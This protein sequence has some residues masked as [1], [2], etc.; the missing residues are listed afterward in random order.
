MTYNPGKSR[1]ISENLS[2]SGTKIILDKETSF[3]RRILWLILVLM[4]FGVMIWQIIKRL[5]DY[6][7][8][9]LAVN[10]E[11]V[12]E[13]HVRFPVLV[14]CNANHISASGAYRMKIRNGDKENNQIRIIKDYFAM[15]VEAYENRTTV[16]E[17][18]QKFEE[19]YG[20]EAHSIL[21]SKDKAEVALKKMSHKLNQML[22]ECWW[23]N[24]QCSENDFQPVMDFFYYKQCYIFNP[25]PPY[26]SRPGIHEGLHLELDAQQYDYFDSSGEK[27]AGF[28]IAVLDDMT[29][30]Y[31]LS[32]IAYQVSTGK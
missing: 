15:I 16:N 14:I 8:Y 17:T 30:I 19:L 20:R 12:F 5:D 28:T 10:M 26:V 31:A 13:K 7:S 1:M 4:M 21:T 2:I 27:T 18:L 24:K 9:P 23:Q 29:D 32:E 6:F 11:I 3:V 22:R 25:D